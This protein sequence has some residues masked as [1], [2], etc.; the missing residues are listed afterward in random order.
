M[1]A[2]NKNNHAATDF[3]MVVMVVTGMTVTLGVF[4]FAADQGV[5]VSLFSLISSSFIMMRV[6]MK[7][8]VMVCQIGNIAEQHVL[9]RRRAFCRMLGAVHGGRR[10]S[11]DKNKHQ[12]DAKRREIRSELER[13]N[14]AH[15][16]KI[17]SQGLQIN[18]RRKM[19]RPT[20]VG[21]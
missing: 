21:S 8:V 17:Q 15:A 20:I 4:M 16:K 5:N 1:I 18:N 13:N 12:R 7:P 6:G 10:R 9:M 19:T 2:G 11:A 14:C 3:A